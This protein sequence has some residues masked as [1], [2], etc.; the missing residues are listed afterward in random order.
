MAI[1]QSLLTNTGFNYAQGEKP[2][3]EVASL[4]V[5]IPLGD[6]ARILRKEHETA[7][8]AARVWEN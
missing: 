3:W 6:T 1:E 5:P 4:A 7:R 2:L 8:K